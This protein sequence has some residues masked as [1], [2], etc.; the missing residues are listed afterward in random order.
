MEFLFKGVQIEARIEQS[1]ETSL[2]TVSGNA[3]NANYI[4]LNG[5]EIFIDKDGSF[6]ESIALIPGYS[7]ITIDATDKFGNDKE[8]KF[9]M[10]YKEGSPAVAFSGGVSIIN[11]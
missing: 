1:G 4:S 5:R 6:K 7:V 8:K 11:N 10:V 3:K 2:A 9:Q